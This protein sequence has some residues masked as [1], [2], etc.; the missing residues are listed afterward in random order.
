[1]LMLKAC[2][3]CHGDMY[4]QSDTY[5]QFKQC[6]QCGFVQ[7]MDAQPAVAAQTPMVSAKTA[8]ANKSVA[9]RKVAIA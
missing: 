4:L 5:G 3:K 6:L 9:T 7:D 2:K 8:A 1:M